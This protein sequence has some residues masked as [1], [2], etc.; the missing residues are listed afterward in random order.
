[1]KLIYIFSI[2]YYCIQITSQQNL[3]SDEINWILHLIRPS[4]IE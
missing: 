3:L 4:G 2:I 1:M